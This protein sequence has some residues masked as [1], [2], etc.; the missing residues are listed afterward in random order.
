MPVKRKIYSTVCLFTIFL[1][2]SGPQVLAQLSVTNN[3]NALSLAQKIVGNG[4]TISNAFLNGGPYAAGTFSY[5]GAHL[6]LT[7][8]IML[9]TG[10]AASAANPGNYFCNVS[11]GSMQA[12][13]DITSISPQAK[14]DVCILEFDFIP[15]C[16]TLKINYVFGSEEYPKAIY[17]TYNDV[18][19]IFLTGPKPGGGNYS[20]QNI[21]TLPNGYTP[22]SID[23]INAGW[24]IG[25][26]ASHFNYYV[27]NYS[28]ANNDIA[29]NGYSVPI[30][31]KAALVTCS[32]YHLK[33]AIADGG[34][35]LY[36]SGVFIQGSSLACGNAPVVT[37]SAITGC[38]DAGTVSVQVSN[39]SGVPSFTWLPGN[40]H[41]D[42]L[43][44]VAAGTYVCL[45]DL[46]GVCGNYSVS[47]TVS[48]QQT[49]SVKGN[50]FLCKGSSAQLIASG[51]ST[52]TWFPSANLNNANIANPVA[53]PSATTIYSVAGTASNGCVSVQNITVTV[54]GQSSPVAFNAS[55]YFTSIENSVIQFTANSGPSGFYWNFGDGSTDT[56]MKP[57]HSFNEPGTYIVSLTVVDSN[58]CSQTVAR[59]IIVNDII[60]DLFTFYAPDAFTP[61]NDQ[62]NDVFQ[63]KGVGWDPSHF[64]LKIYNK[65]GTMIFATDDPRKAWDGREGGAVLGSD[66]YVW[67]VYL[68]DI[69]KK[70][71]NFI[72]KVTLLR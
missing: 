68:K 59:E 72:G 36:D 2:F 35:A 43:K 41:S 31:S 33:I 57:T 23:S 65:W 48:P 15:L 46:P 24:P 3:N 9:T 49:L 55:S 45:V 38:A 6:G 19:A 56:I 7:N 22:V 17:Q 1:L 60:P 44:D 50:A 34:N 37:S 21:A 52:Y 11:N 12:D 8:G 51:V 70:E 67:Q 47:A 25:T 40:Q 4:I 62:V 66:V 39:Y 58:N 64:K 54:G 20:A 13:P 30:T 42:T 63:L 28:S 29:Y 5:S 61:N 69:Y 71:H 14:Y 18:F 16:D 32:S 10:T 26:N 53:S 27:D